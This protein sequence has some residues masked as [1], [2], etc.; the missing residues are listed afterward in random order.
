MIPSGLLL[1]FLGSGLVALPFATSATTELQRRRMDAAALLLAAAV[2]AT[3][4]VF[5]VRYFYDV[6]MPY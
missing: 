3:G 5:A 4:V 6:V 1:V 2:L